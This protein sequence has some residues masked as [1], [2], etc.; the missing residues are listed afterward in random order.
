MPVSQRFLP[1]I[2]S[3][4]ACSTGS[5]LRTW[6]RVKRSSASC[7]QYQSDDRLGTTPRTVLF[8]SGLRLERLDPFA[9][10]PSYPPGANVLRPQTAR[11][12]KMCDRVRVVPKERQLRRTGLIEPIAVL[13]QATQAQHA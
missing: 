6:T 9:M 13:D 11:S 12:E 2:A 3:A 5:P 7:S 10:A 8:L 4:S 1:M